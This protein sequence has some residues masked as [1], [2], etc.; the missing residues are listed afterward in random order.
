L[1]RPGERAPPDLLR[2]QPT[3]RQPTRR[4][5]RG[6]DLLAAHQRR[7]SRTK[8]SGAAR[9]PVRVPFAAVPLIAVFVPLPAPGRPVVATPLADV[10]AVDAHVAV[11]APLVVVAGPHVAATIGRRL[12]TD[13]GRRLGGPIV[14]DHLGG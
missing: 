11:V 12:F 8:L 3:R 2:R 14:D 6:R 9:L 1:G 5:P 10:A 4:Q 13:D 7:H